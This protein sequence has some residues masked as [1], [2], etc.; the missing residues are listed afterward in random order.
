MRRF[1]SFLL[2]VALY[3]PLIASSLAQQSSPDDLTASVVVVGQAKAPQMVQYSPEL[4]LLSAI[5][6]AGGLEDHVR[7]FLVRNGKS[8]RI[9]I[10]FKEIQK[11]PQSDPIMKPWDTIVILRGY[12]PS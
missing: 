7:V 3:S 1:L 10:D 6:A 9:K 12:W 11:N 8:E 2:I 5:T 4:T